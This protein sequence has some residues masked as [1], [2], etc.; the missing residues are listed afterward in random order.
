MSKRVMHM[1]VTYKYN[2][3]ERKL[4]EKEVKYRTAL[5]EAKYPQQETDKLLLD[6][7]LKQAAKFRKLDCWLKEGLCFIARG[8]VSARLNS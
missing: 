3:R 6:Y 1:N 5:F 2:K 7:Y 8:I 4:A